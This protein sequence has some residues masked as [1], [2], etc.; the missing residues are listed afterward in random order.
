MAAR[1]LV[2]SLSFSANKKYIRRRLLLKKLDRQ[3]LHNLEVTNYDLQIT[4]K[5]NYKL[6]ELHDS[7]KCLL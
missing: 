2:D 7:K 4:I 5:L 3:K 1:N 6:K